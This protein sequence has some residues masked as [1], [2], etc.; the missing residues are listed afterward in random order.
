[1]KKKEKKR[2]KNALLAI[3]EGKECSLAPSAKES[4]EAAKL[5]LKKF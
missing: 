2:I 1:M 3:V 5:L 4:I